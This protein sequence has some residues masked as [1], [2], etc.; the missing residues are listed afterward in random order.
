MSLI[1]KKTSSFEPAPEGLH[2]AVCIDVVDLGIEDGQFGAKHKCRIVWELAELM[3]SGD[4]YIASKKYTVSLHEKSALHKDLKSWR[5]KPFTAEE[6]AGFDVE[7]V[8]GAPCQILIEQQ[9]KDGSVY[10]NIMAVTKADKKSRLSP[11]GKYVRVKDRPKANG[12]D[13]SAS[14]EPGDEPDNEEEM[15]DQIPF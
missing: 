2:S 14:R 9:E 1:A 12:E 15:G 13:K 6:M 5:G 8:I 3:P 10:A 7:K 11:S 4:R